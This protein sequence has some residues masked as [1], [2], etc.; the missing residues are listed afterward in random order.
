M[1]GGGVAAVVFRPLTRLAF[2]P[3]WGVFQAAVYGPAVAAT[4]LSYP[5]PSTIAGALSFIAY[6]KGLCGG[7]QDRD[8][9]LTQECLEGVL[10]GGFAVR[11]GLVRVAGRLYYY[12]GGGFK[13][14]QGG[15]RLK[16]ARGRYVGVALDRRAKTNLRV[17]EK[18]HIFNVSVIE[19][20]L[21]GPERLEFVALLRPGKDEG[22]REFLAGREPARLG[23]EHAYA[24]QAVVD[25]E[26]LDRNPLVQ[27][28]GGSIARIV[29]VT[30]ALL[31]LDAGRGVPG[32]S[33]GEPILAS[34]S[35]IRSILEELINQSPEDVRNC[36]SLERADKGNNAGIPRNEL[37]L[38]VVQPGW[39][40]PDDSPRKPHLL[41][42]AG[43]WMTVK[44][45][46]SSCAD[47]VAWQGLGSHSNLGWGS[48]LLKPGHQK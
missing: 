35:L 46:D 4:T 29:L 19:P 21:G 33:S 39:S 27:V 47:K 48:P 6:R 28:E 40:T 43:T 13:E 9:E 23:G 3:P 34:H 18:G 14:V 42:P 44:L 25:L 31:E 11:P 36:V 24:G 32:I 10:G 20:V 17:E 7:G 45:E 30:P 8:F 15:G 16:P 41:I 38:E 37:Q 26:R 5:L 2:R 22:L 12:D 1:T